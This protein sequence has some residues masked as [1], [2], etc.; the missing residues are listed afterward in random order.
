MVHSRTA[1][2]TLHHESMTE[3]AQSKRQG[4]RMYQVCCTGAF[5]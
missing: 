5:V 4:Q 3:Q 1:T 2:I